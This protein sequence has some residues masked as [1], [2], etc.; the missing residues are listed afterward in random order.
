MEALLN[1]RKEAIRHNGAEYYSKEVLIQWINAMDHQYFSENTG[2]K[3][4]VAE[5]DG[6]LIG[7]IFYSN[8][9]KISGLYISP[10]MNKQGVGS[11]LLSK[12]EE[13]IFSIKENDST[14]LNS[15]LNSQDFYSK[16]GYLYVQD[17]KHKFRG[18]RSMQVIEMKKS[19]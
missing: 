8:K 9:G 5:K 3:C 7:F 6:A 14:Y 12:A 16:M 13:N 2:T 1:I 19:K 4:L 15:S 11:Q 10:S 18:G 17:K